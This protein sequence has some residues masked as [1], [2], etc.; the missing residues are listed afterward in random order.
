[1]DT[2]PEAHRIQ[3]E[4]YARMGG[5]ARLSV[6]FELT[7]ATRRITIAGI[8]HRHPEYTDEQVSSA[9]ARLTLGDDLCQ[10][11]WPGRPLVTP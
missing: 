7:D 10:E 8:R 5:V 2:S 9:W 4:I 3:S 6:A 1:M 11:V